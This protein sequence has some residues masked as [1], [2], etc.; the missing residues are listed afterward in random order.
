MPKYL[1]RASYT[2]EGVQGIRTSGGTSRRDAV[3][4]TAKSLGGQLESFYFA[5]GDHDAEVVVDLPDNEA[6][7]AIALTVNASGGASVR[8]TV[9]LTPEQVDDAAKRSVD[10]RPPGG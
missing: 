2:T 6:A 7:A 5:F 3:A 9:L 8:T 1:I 4:A 10:Y